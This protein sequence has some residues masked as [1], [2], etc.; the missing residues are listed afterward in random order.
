VHARVC[1]CVPVSVSVSATVPVSV[2][3]SVSVSMSM[4]MS[5]SVLSSVSMCLCLCLC[6]CICGELWHAS[7]WLFTFWL[8]GGACHGVSNVGLDDCCLGNSGSYLSK[9]KSTCKYAHHLEVGTHQIQQGP[10]QEQVQHAEKME[11]RPA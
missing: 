2:S 7:C 10:Q 4:S 8:A 9:H 11:T 1:V 5:V 6:L 3:V